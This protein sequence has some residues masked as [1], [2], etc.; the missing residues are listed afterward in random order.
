[1]QK[2]YYSKEER[3]EYDA[4]RYEMFKKNYSKESVWYNEVEEDEPIKIICSVFGCGKELTPT[5]RLFGNKCFTHQGKD[6][7][8]TYLF[9][10]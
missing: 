10:C 9:N 6:Q 8:V 2:Q 5:E 1:M 7:D 4:K 3:K